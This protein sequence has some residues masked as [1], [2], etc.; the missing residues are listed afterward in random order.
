MEIYKQ[1][2]SLQERLNRA[3]VKADILDGRSNS[4]EESIESLRFNLGSPNNPELF[5]PHFLKK[6]FKNI[7]GCIYTLDSNSDTI[8]A[9]FL[10]PQ[11]NGQ[12]K[13][14]LNFSPDNSSEEHKKNILLALTED[15][16]KIDLFYPSNI[17]SFEG[18]YSKW[19][20]L[21]IGHPSKLESEQ[22][23]FLQTKIW[24][25]EED[26]LYPSAIHHP[27]F[28]LGTSLVVR[29]QEKVLG[30]LFGFYRF[31][32]QSLPGFLKDK[33][34]STLRIESQL[35]GVMPSYRSEGFGYKL[36]TTQRALALQKEIDII[37]W[38][39][40]PL[41]YANAILNFGK[42]RA[43]AY[44]FNENYYS[45]RNDLNQVPASRID[46][47]WFINSNRVANCLNSKKSNEPL[48]ID[49]N[50]L[51]SLSILNNGPKANNVQDN[52]S[53]WIAFEIPEDWSALQKIDLA[54]A[55]L[56]RKT[57]DSL[58]KKYLG[59]DGGVYAICEVGKDF[60]TNKSYLLARKMEHIQG[61]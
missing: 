30:F 57:T 1:L 7:G 46:V 13:A 38:T 49:I 18:S 33:Y 12:H 40:D 39:V 59:V 11:R 24:G 61:L 60:V 43:I 55:V 21:E 31:S 14:F 36:K 28:N 27:D 48:I 52:K 23:R 26:F 20:G 51:D 50:E 8:G 54:R 17:S 6:T 2:R 4:W 44:D 32:E 15:E 22:I 45:F 5:P 9:L 3:S 35:M 42:L 29:N 41:Q 56:W 53:E 58:F 25:S 47:T 10:F 34:K 19:G 16:S 37:N